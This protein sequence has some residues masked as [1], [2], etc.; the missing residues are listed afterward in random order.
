MQVF[1]LQI[2]N[3]PCMN[4]MNPLFSLHKF[5]RHFLGVNPRRRLSFT[6]SLKID[7]LWQTHMMI[8][9][10]HMVLCLGLKLHWSFQIYYINS[11]ILSMTR[12]F[13]GRTGLFYGRTH[14]WRRD[15]RW[16]NRPFLRQNLQVADRHSIDHIVTSIQVLRSQI[17]G[18][19]VQL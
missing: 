13:Y 19:Q 17:L 3:T 5:N 14:R 15:T 7:E 10:T 4:L 6:W 8:A 11:L 2:F 9:L 18:F 16:Q 1:Y 12:Q